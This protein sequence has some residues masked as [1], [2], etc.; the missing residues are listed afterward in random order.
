MHCQPRLRAWLLALV[1]V[2]SASGLRVAF[3]IGSPRSMR[4]RLALPVMRTNETGNFGPSALQRRALPRA[5]RRK[6]GND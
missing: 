6:C 5:A 4:S 3:S 1:C 2:G